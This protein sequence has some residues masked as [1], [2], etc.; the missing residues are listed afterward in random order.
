ML[1]SSVVIR[2]GSDKIL[3][4]GIVHWENVEGANKNSFQDSSL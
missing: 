2:D 1:L 3:A 4:I